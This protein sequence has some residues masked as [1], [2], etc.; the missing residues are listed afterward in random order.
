MHRVAQ[1]NC[2]RSRNEKREGIPTILGG[3]FVVVSP[4]GVGGQ[5]G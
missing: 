2:G 5:F 3:R 1:E 4:S